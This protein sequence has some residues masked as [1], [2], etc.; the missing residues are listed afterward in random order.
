MIVWAASRESPK[1]L[2]TALTVRH[3]Y[4]T[5]IAKASKKRVKRLC[6]SA[7]DGTIVF[8]PWSGQRH[9]GSRATNTVVNCIVT[10]SRQR[11]SSA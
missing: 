5:S 8:T 2:A 11:R 6:F 7:H 4:R 10:R 1:K 3:A 9:R